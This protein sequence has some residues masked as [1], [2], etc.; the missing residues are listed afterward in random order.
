VSG[1]WF[2]RCFMMTFPIH[3]MGWL[4]YAPLFM[5][6]GLWAAGDSNLLIEPQWL[7]NAV[8]ILVIVALVATAVALIA[9]TE[10]R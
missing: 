5:A 9:K 3:L 4:T 7:S 2:R 6:F 10:K 8:P 1:P